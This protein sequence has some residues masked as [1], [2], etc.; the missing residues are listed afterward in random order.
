[1]N[2]DA[3][4]GPTKIPLSR[5][6]EPALART[7]RTLRGGVS[8]LPLWLSDIQCLI[9]GSSLGVLKLKTGQMIY[10]QYNF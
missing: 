5:G 7:L 10:G 8:S 4:T 6:C 3:H 1:M 9:P 2:T